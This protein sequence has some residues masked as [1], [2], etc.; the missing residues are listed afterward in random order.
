M[1]TTAYLMPHTSLQLISI[2]YELLMSVGL[3]LNLEKMLYIFMQKCLKRLGLNSIHVYSFYNSEYP[4]EY[5]NKSVFVTHFRS[6]PQNKGFHPH[7]NN[8]VYAAITKL[9]HAEIK[10]PVTVQANET[11]YLIFYIRDFGILVLDKRQL[12]AHISIP[13][14]ITPVIERLATACQACVEHMN[15]S[16]EIEAKIYAEK[17]YEINVKQDPLTSLSNRNCFHQRLYQEVA[18]SLRHNEYGAVLF[19]DLDHFNKINDSLSHS[20]GDALLTEIA[21][22]LQTQAR[23]EDN[24]FRIGGDEFAILLNNIGTTRKQAS[25]IAQGIAQRI[26]EHIT[27]PVVIKEQILHTTASIGIV[28]FPD[29]EVKKI[30]Y[31]LYSEQIAQNADI[32]LFRAKKRGR[33]RYEFYK[34]NMQKE[35]K[36]Y[37]SIA[38]QLIDAIKNGELTLEYQ[39]L[40]DCNE[41]I[42]GAEALLRWNNPVLGIV[43]P[44]EFIPVAEESGL[45]KI[46]GEWVLHSVCSFVKEIHLTAIS[47]LQ[48]ISINISQIQFNQQSF[49]STVKGIIKQYDIPAKLIRLEITESLFINN[50]EAIISK[51]KDLSTFGVQ[52]LL[53]DFGTGYSS[54]SNIQHLPICTIKID[55][56]FISNINL[57]NEANRA[58][59]SAIISLANHVCLDCIAEGVE[60]AEDAAFCKS[61][62]IYA[63]QG[64]YYYYPLPKEDFITILNNH[65]EQLEQ[66]RYI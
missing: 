7:N 58:L 44:D 9:Y 11:F 42:I 54:L 6:I 22:R 27:K 23:A 14:A 35:A 61:K 55:K 46:L 25:H 17:A 56:V 4:D 41:V 43:S 10:S 16:R 53:D 45:I 57:K 39:P 30:D 21:R 49:V 5:N 29:K 40:L 32:A 34:E 15:I 64:Y 31:S 13:D 47:S 12:P 33:N 8:D 52:F 26:C 2:Q 62:N 37:H 19:I 48:Y 1:K 20:T 36:R 65:N 51:M 59:T 63:M 66:L 38:T 3:D 28:L 50:R 60:T 18:R 24:I